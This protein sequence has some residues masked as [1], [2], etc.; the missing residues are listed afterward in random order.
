MTDPWKEKTLQAI[1][2][3]YAKTD[4]YNVKEFGLFYKALPRKT[5]H[6][7]DDKCTANKHGTIRVTGPATANKNDAKLSMFIISK[8]KK[9]MLFKNVKKFLVVT[10]ARTKAEWIQRFSKTESESLIIILKKNPGK[11]H[12]SLITVLLIQIFKD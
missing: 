1:L 9:P 10:Q 2:S 6:L 3:N 12:S 8:S 7:K 4:V 5:L 11:L